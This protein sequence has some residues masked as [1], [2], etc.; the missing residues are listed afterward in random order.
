LLPPVSPTGRGAA[1]AAPAKAKKASVKRDIY[2][3]ITDDIVRKL[4][5]GVRPSIRNEMRIGPTP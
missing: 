5:S 2:Q 3:E 4:E 1:A